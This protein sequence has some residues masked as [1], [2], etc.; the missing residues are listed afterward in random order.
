MHQPQLLV[1]DDD[2]QIR[3]VYTR[4]LGRDFAVECAYDVA[5][6]LAI[7]DARAQKG[8]APFDVVLCDLHLGATS[9]RDFYDELS[10]RS[11]ELR[12]RVV[13]ITG[14][15]ATRGDVFADAL[16]D[17]YILK[18]AKLDELR[19]TLLRL[20]PARTSVSAA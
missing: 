1:I 5:S 4:T 11:D 2:A 14:L 20:V 8:V 18:T 9:G 19:E 7:I 16:G 17:R 3:R 15:P 13:I 10:R 6:A 12:D